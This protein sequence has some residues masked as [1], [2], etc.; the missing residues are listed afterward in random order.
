MR[1]CTGLFHA[2]ADSDCA[3]PSR[4]A[5]RPISSVLRQPPATLR[6]K[7][8]YMQAAPTTEGIALSWTLQAALTAGVAVA[9]AGVALTFKRPAMRALAAALAM[10]SLASAIIWA[11]L[12]A[13]GWGFPSLAIAIMLAV[14]P[15]MVPG[16]AALFYRQIVLLMSGRATTAMPPTNV[17]VPISAVS[18]GFFLAI[19]I[20][21]EHFMPGRPLGIALLGTFAAIAASFWLYF[22]AT[23]ARKLPGV[24]QL[25]LMML[26]ISFIALALRS[27][28]NIFVAA[29]AFITGEAPVF[30]TGIIVSQVFLLAISAV[31]QLVAVLDEER[32]HILV[33]A[34]QIR[35]AERQMMSS[36]RMESLGRMAGAVAHD[37]NN[38]LTVI[39]MSAHSAREGADRAIWEDLNEISA[40]AVRGKALTEQLLAFARQSPQQVTRFDARA[41]VERLRTLIDRVAGKNAILTIESADALQ[42]VDMDVTQ[43][44]Q[45]VLNL[46]LNAR[47]AM[48]DGGRISIRTGPTA[49]LSGEVKGFVRVS[50][51]DTG[52]GIRPE[53]LSH[54]FEPF[55]STKREGEG[56]GLGLAICD[57]IVRAVG[58]RIEVQ[59]TVGK[60]TRFDVLLPRAAGQ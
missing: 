15:S 28:V 55:F 46:V 53:V 2:F 11:A 45:V 44:E 50:V 35:Q 49:G 8:L 40:S 37:F 60:G 39:S 58:G 47:D 4:W 24:K 54:I 43:F 21:G 51:E 18:L 41:Q 14:A 13:E 7:P 42:L 27:M 29:V 34:E 1:R 9:G 52:A 48:P 33:Q 12:S 10:V 32:T 17:L 38:V 31:L 57:G 56:T 22:Q 6:R 36:Q 3:K 19:A 25:P 20:V 23:A 26:Q 30:S 5:P 16:M 59:S